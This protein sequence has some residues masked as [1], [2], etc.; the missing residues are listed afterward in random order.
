MK[1]NELLENYKNLDL[2]KLPEQLT[3]H[4]L[5]FYLVERTESKLIFQQEK[6]AAS[7]EVF[8][9]KIIPERETAESFAKRYNTP[10][11]ATKYQDYK[12]VYPKNSE[13]G[14]RAWSYPRLELAKQKYNSLA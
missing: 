13:F 9:N 6:P 7:F 12:E 4:G 2:R 8:I 10:Y 1:Q 5:D 14:L 11:D 3:Q